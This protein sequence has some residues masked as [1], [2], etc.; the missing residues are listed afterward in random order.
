[1][2]RIH[3]K[4][5]KHLPPPKGNSI[6]LRPNKHNLFNHN[7]LKANNSKTQCGPP[8]TFT[9]PRDLVRQ[10]AGR[11]HPLWTITPLSGQ[12]RT[13]V[14]LDCYLLPAFSKMTYK[15]NP[16]SPLVPPHLG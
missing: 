4:K 9:S 10:K 15:K 11:D 2:N 1:M 5:R 16:N 7:N 6:I 13:G 8:P 3:M 12:G 14:E